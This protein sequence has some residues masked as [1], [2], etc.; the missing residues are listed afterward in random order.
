M[1]PGQPFQQTI[2]ERV[3]ISYPAIDA[4]A[5]D[6]VVDNYAERASILAAWLRED[7]FLLSLSRLAPAKGVDDLIRGYRAS[8]WYGH[9]PLVVAALVSS[10]AIACLGRSRSAHHVL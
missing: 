5:Y 2:A 8:A 9:R 3:G 6:A 10:E 1:Q 4:G 7:G